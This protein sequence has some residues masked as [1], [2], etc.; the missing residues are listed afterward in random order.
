MKPEIFMDDFERT[1]L[2]DAHYAAIGRLLTFASRFEAV[3]KGISL[4]VG[5]KKK[6]S[7]IDSDSALNEFIER[8]R[9]MPLARHLSDLGLDEGSAGMVLLAARRARNEIAHT[10]T[11]GLDRCLDRLSREQRVEFVQRLEELAVSLA[12]GDRVISYLASVS[13]S[14]HLPSPNFLNEYPVRVA[15]WVCE[16]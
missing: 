5:L 2:S 7:L 14:E 10:L 12:E 6:R 1:E 13:T 3:A 16:L 4:L 9:K 8:L 15:A 11:I